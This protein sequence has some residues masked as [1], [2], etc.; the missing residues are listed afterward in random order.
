MDEYSSSSLFDTSAK[1]RPT[2]LSV[3]SDLLRRARELGINL[4]GALEE[5]LV[6][7]LARERREDWIRENRSAIDGYNA[8]VE[9]GGSFGD[10][11][12]RF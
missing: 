5:A 1:K 8:R 12:R 6:E 9:S 7:R 4:S 10:K 3:N 2:N 11:V